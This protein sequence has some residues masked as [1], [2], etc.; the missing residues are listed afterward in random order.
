M[1][2]KPDIID[3]STET[4][5]TPL[6]KTLGYREQQ[7]E[8]LWERSPVL[9]WIVANYIQIMRLSGKMPRG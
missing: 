5:E 1:S 8:R 4:K 6:V 9:F 3:P 2:G 7:P